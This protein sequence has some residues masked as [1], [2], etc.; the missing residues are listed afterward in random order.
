[1]VLIALK[2]P[3][4]SGTVQME[5]NMKSGFCVHCGSKILNEQSMSGTVSI[6]KSTDIINNLKFAKESL[7]MHEW[8][9]ANR[10]V[11]SVLT[12][13]ADCRDAWYMKALINYRDATHKS[14]IDKAEGKGMKNYEI[15]SKADIRKCWGEYDI[16]VIHEVTRKTR[17]G[18]KAQVKIDGKDPLLIEK[19]ETKLFGVNSGKHVISASFVLPP[20]APS[21]EVTFSFVASKNHI[22]IIE[23]QKV[24]LSGLI[25]KPKIVE[26]S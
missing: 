16:R 23:V 12:L 14:L 15:F 19:G 7:K 17:P 22:F 3:H 11:E 2:C 25:V 6:D 9:T 10:L 1:M 13:D 24:G 20:L 5:E 8:E 26:K 18:V 4:C 21:E